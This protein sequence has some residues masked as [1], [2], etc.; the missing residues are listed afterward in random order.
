MGTRCLS[1]FSVLFVFLV[2]HFIHSE[3]TPFTFLAHLKNKLGQ[4]I[5]RVWGEWKLHSVCSLCI[6]APARTELTQQ[7]LT[8]IWELR[9]T[10]VPC[11]PATKFEVNQMNGEEQTVTYIQGFQMSN[12]HTLW[13]PTGG[14]IISALADLWQINSFQHVK[15]IS[16]SVSHFFPSLSYF[17]LRFCC[18]STTS[19]CSWSL[20]SVFSSF[21][22]PTLTDGLQPLFHTANM[23][24][25]SGFWQQLQCAQICEYSWKKFATSSAW[26]WELSQCSSNKHTV[27]IGELGLSGIEWN[28]CRV[29]S[30]HSEKDA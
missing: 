4:M 24:N 3:W 18:S 28:H 8:K 19:S 6:Y 9:G 16:C 22:T 12:V 26:C 1:T 5:D 23:A 17:P 25:F 15:R 14:S 29:K 21:L 13:A 7:L 2:L 11:S 20:F 10:R 27:C 30:T